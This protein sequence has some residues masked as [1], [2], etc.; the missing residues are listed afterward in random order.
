MRRISWGGRELFAV[1]FSPDGATLV[2]GGLDAKVALFKTADASLVRELDGSRG[3]VVSLSFSKDG[4][5][6]AIGAEPGLVVVWDLVRIEPVLRLRTVDNSF[7]AA[8]VAGGAALAM[9]DNGQVWT[10]GRELLGGSTDPKSLLDE[11]ERDAG[12]HID[13][14]TLVRGP[15]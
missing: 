13:G 14:F 11:A 8:F 2:A 1:A 9:M 4:R 7:R 10:V 6:L 3:T 15:R 12:A 5:F